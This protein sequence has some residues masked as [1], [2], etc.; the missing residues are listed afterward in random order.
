MLLVFSGALVHGGSKYF[1]QEK[2]EYQS[3]IR[4][5]FTIAENKYNHDVCEMTHNLTNKDVC[6]T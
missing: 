3:C 1:V 4:L 2:V 6:S 5:F